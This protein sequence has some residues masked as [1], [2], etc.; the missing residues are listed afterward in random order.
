MTSSL[1]EQFLAQECTFYVRQLLEEATADA[2]APRPHFEFNRFEVTVE[3]DD[4]VVL[5]EDVLDSTEA[6]VQRVPLA[7]FVKAILRCSA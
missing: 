7:E 2:S 1:L 4:S 6:D 5:L 3:R